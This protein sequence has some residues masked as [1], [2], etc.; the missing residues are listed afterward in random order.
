L[1]YTFD[2]S[3]TGVFMPLINGKQI[4]IGSKKSFDVFEDPNLEKYAP[5]DFIKI[6]PSHLELLHPKMKIYNGDLLTK[7]L[8]IGGEALHKSQVNYFNEEGLNVEIINE[9]GP[10]EATVGCSTFSFNALKDYNDLKNNIPIGKP[11]DNMQLYIVDENNNLLPYGIP[12]ELCIGGEGLARGYLNRPELTK[13]KFIRNPFS[14][15]KDS[16]IYKTGDIASWLPD[17]NIEFAGRK[18]DQIKIRG[19]RVEL[20]EIE[21]AI[22]ESETVSQVVVIA[23]ESKEGS[24]RLIAYIVGKENFDKEK[25]ISKLQNR[26]PEYMIP[27]QWVELDELPLTKNGKLDRKSLPDPE[28]KTVNDSEDSLPRND[29]EKTLVTIWQELLDAETVGIHDNFFELG[30]D[31]II[32]IQIVSRARRAGYEIQVADVFSYQ[33]ISKLSEI[34]DLKSGTSL[35]TNFEQGLLEGRAGLTPIQQWFFENAGNNSNLYNHFNQGVLLSID[36]NVSFENLSSAVQQIIFHHDAL[37]FIY[38]NE[39]GQWSQ[40]YGTQSE[41]LITVDLQSV[42][43]DSLGNSIR[44]HSDKY[45]KS[46]NIEKGEIAKFVFI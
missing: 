9:Y 36:K 38:Q 42:E 41:P 37:R 32:I 8:V 35:V 11:I 24:K 13:E 30:G 4:V 44:E 15:D 18:D 3:I 5:Y 14:E 34:M 1:S 23:K 17:G 29:F 10:T 31:S 25:L 33:T 26:L 22:R 2:A 19:Y 43:K 40:K 21:N 27:S 46:L 12:G 20:G 16:R 7:K 39:N 6:T 28:I 45:Q